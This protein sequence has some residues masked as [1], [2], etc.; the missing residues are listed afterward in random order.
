M[1]MLEQ[2]GTDFLR[3][4]SS[5]EPVPGG[6]GASAAVGALGAALGM[7]VCNLTIGKKKY[8]AYE[9]ELREE[10]QLLEQLR[11][12]LTAMVDAD[13]EAFAPLSHAYGLPRDTEAQQAERARVMEA[14]LV[15][16]SEAPLALM[17]TLLRT[18][19]ALELLVEKGSRLAVSDVGV[20]AIFAQAAMEGASLN[21]FINTRLMADADKAAALENE[22]DDLIARGDAFKER[23]CSG[24]GN[25]IRPG[26]K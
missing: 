3:V 13:A 22:A 12:E 6:G 23:I 15:T 21:V 19:Q 10:L 14:A 24:V 7:M 26:V 1:G 5:A 8:A 2:K 9:A 4:L 25:L 11:D 20:A 18:E 16:A 17:R